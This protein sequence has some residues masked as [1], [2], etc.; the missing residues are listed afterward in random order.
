MDD[1]IWN[2]LPA[3]VRAVVDAHLRGGRMVMAVAAVRDASADP[4]PGLHAAV[5]FLVERRAAIAA[6]A[7]A[8]PLDPAELAALAEGLSFR[9]EAVE[10][11]WRE[12]GEAPFV[13][14][15]A[16]A[17]GPYRE[18]EL[19]AVRAGAELLG[20]GDGR[21]PRS[22]A[23]T[24]RELGRAVAERLGVSFWF[25]APEGPAEDAARWWQRPQMV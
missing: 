20:S 6:P 13:L 21:S 14:L 4:K 8:T 12:E 22:E 3:P 19:A 10:A 7:P 5:D 17:S 23:G 1:R 9:P 18:A 24:A 25:G 15:L 16:V 2:A 11:V